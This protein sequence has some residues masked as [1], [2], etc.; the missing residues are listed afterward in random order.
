MRFTKAVFPC[1]LIA[2][3]PDGESLCVVKGGGAVC[4]TSVTWDAQCKITPVIISTELNECE[5]LSGL[6]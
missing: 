2:R 6:R 5:F 3:V 4:L 1:M